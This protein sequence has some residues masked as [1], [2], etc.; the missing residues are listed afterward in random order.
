M[1][2]FDYLTPENPIAQLIV[3][4]LLALFMIWSALLI[5]SL[6]R[7]L[8]YW[9][10][11]NRCKDVG[12]LR[13]QQT[14]AENGQPESV[15]HLQQAGAEIFQAFQQDKRL[16]E[17]GPITRHLRAVFEAGWN[18][19]QLDSRGL[20]KNTT[21]QLFRINSLHRSLLS[22]F[23]I[24]GLLGTLFGLADTLASLDTLLHG[25]NQINNDILGQSLQRLLGTLKSAFA[26]SIWGVSLTVLGVLIFAFYMRAIALPLSGLL[27]RMTL[28][29]WIPQLVPTT[30]QKLLDKL[31]L[32]ERQM[33]R[34]FEAAKQVAEFAEGI[35]EQTG[36]FGETLG[37][38]TKKLKQM[39]RVSDN[40][41]TFSQNF[42]AGVKVLAPFQQEL[43]GLYQQMLDE[44]RAFQE[45][46]QSNI[47]GSQDFQKQIQNQLNSQHSQL[48]Q[49]LNSLQSYEAAYVT[50]RER[51]DE[52]LGAVLIQAEKAFESL[53]QRNEE[54]GAALDASLGKPLRENLAVSLGAVQIE[55][56]GRLTEIKDTLEVQLSSTGER[57][58]R[59][60]EPLN[61]AA[62]NFTDTFSN[63]NETTRGWLEKLQREF[64]N[65]NETNQ[66]QLH[67]LE[68]LGEQIPK[69]LQ[70]LSD[71]SKN[72]SDT[73]GS[74]AV[75]GQ[76]LSADV[77]TL[78]QNI[79]TLGTSV[80]ALSEQVTL[81]KSVAQPDAAERL[82]K[83]I[84][85]QTNVLQQLGNKIQAVTSGQSRR[86]ETQLH[87][88]DRR[89]GETQFIASDL[90][91]R[92]RLRS[93]LRMGKR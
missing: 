68:T 1:K 41:E 90:R 36:E 63:F 16:Q 13:A 30:S 34:S 77:K 69:L 79:G 2:L 3:Y 33:Q 25:T 78:S 23:I 66:Q 42:V 75:H 54:I 55:L 4:L 65:Q 29:V 7:H 8:L 89:S 86:R 88:S 15:L 60:D 92:D 87:G 59:L 24:L 80:E 82:A 10:Q 17:N 91:W 11:I 49:V 85:R 93:W 38:A 19:S 67:R 47:A 18:E 21:D 70:T 81:N 12:G 27:E 22:I 31:Q 20:I 72:F 48:A 53:G 58:G 71:S 76:Q 44:S 46:V 56:Q 32:S 26:P 83:L 61:K 6:L 52:K 37:L 35:K 51:I 62:Q 73:S 45:S 9:S 28:T 43:R 57:L 39:T 50:N 84:E 64:A 40:L 5:L 74:F 14:R